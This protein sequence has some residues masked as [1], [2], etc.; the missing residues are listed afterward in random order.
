MQKSRIRMALT[1]LGVSFGIAMGQDCKNMTYE[2][3]NQ[4]DPS[5]IRV[6]AVQGVVQDAERVKIP[7]ACVGIFTG[8]DHQLVG[9]SQ[10]GEDG[11]FELKGIDSGDYRLVAKY[12]GFCVANARL[13]LTAGTR[14][15]KALVVHMKPG[16]IDGCSYVDQKM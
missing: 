14:R 16:S 3:R 12:D 2:S 4:I 1:I 8:A 7:R 6:A 10:T 15:V 5:P 11:R 13:R 9:V